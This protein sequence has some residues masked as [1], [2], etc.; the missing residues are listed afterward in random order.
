[1]LGGRNGAAAR[2]FRFALDDKSAPVGGMRSRY[3]KGR[4]MYQ[5]PLFREERPEVMH[6]LM[7]AHPFATLVMLEEGALS[8]NH[9]PLVIHPELSE[10][11]VLRGHVSKGNP[12]WTKHDPTVEALAIFQGP[13]HYVT[14]SWYPSKKA[15]GKVVPTWNYAVVHAY[16]TLETYEDPTRLLAHLNEL[17]NRNEIERPVPW[18]V[19]DAPDEFVAKQLKGIVGLEIAITRLEGKWK[20]SQNRDEKDR[21]GVSR[22]LVV[23]NDRDAAA[24][25][26]LVAQ[27]GD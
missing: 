10:N 13:Q 8:A 9:I 21:R 26:D 17:T 14:P 3:G 24:M 20:V 23:E 12:L 5:P 15:H 25:S 18:E 22:G 4:T 16:G 6:G 7:R 27:Y 11:G 1:M 2:H 19:S